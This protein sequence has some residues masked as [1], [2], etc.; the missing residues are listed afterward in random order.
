LLPELDA[1]A[2]LRAVVFRSADPDFFLMH[3]DVEAL[4]ASTPSAA[5]PATEPSI[6]AAAFER[7]ALAARGRA[8]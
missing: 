5:A 3:G 4:T 6:A 7:L 2:D 8:T 1:D